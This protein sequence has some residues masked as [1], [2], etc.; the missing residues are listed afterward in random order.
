MN[1]IEVGEYVRTEKGTIG[2]IK[3]EENLTYGFGAKQTFYRYFDKNEE[4]QEEIIK[5]SKNI[6]D[7]IE[8]R[9]L[10]KWQKNNR[11]NSAKQRRNISMFLYE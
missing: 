6:I 8:I 11:I 7:L 1:E 4:I 9:R 3:A 2:K 5:H 10:Y